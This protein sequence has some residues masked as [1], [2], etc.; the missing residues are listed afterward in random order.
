MLYGT[1]LDFAYPGLYP[2]SE[3]LG[4]AHGGGGGGGGGNGG[5]MP[6]PKVQSRGSQGP[7]KT[8]SRIIETVEQAPS[9]A[10]A[11]QQ[12]QMAMAAQQPQQIAIPNHVHAAALAAAQ[13]QYYAVEAD[14]SY[15]EKLSQKRRDVWKLLLYAF[16]I[17][18][19]LSIH[20]LMKQAIKFVTKQYDLSIRNTWLLRG[21]YP[22]LIIFLMWNIKAIAL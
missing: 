19:A 3:L 11:Q 2:P 22:L 17:L 13:K 10:Q 14:A 1:D 7:A 6:M 5:G 16:I 21:A 4:D 8:N 12:Q 20:G 9:Q 18:T 15:L